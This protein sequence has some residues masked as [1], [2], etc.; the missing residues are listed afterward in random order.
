MSYNYLPLDRKWLHFQQVKNLLDFDQLVS[1]T[2]DAHERILQCRGYLD[3]IQTTSDNVTGSNAHG[4]IRVD[5][6]HVEELQSN[7]LKSHA[8]GVGEEVPT[9]LVK[10][11]LML[12]IKALSFGYSGVQ[13]ETVKRLM[14]LYNNGAI[15]IVYTQGSL[16]AG[17]HVPL[18][19]LSLPL[20]GL[21]QVNY[22]G[23][24]RASADVLKELKLE[25]V[26]LQSNEGLAL[27]TG[28]QFMSAYG[29]YSL[30]KTEQLLKMADAIAALSFD[31]FGC[32]LQ[33][34]HEKLHLLRSHKGQ[35]DTASAI[36][37]YL[38]GSELITKHK[39]HQQD[40]YSFTCI[41]QVHGAAK[42]T[43]SYVLDVFLKEINS[44]TGDPVIFYEDDLILSGGNFHGQ[45]LALALDFLSIAMSNLAS[46]SERRIHQLVSGQ[47]GLPMFPA[48]N[49][50][51]NGVQILQQTAAAIASENKQLC[52]PASVDNNAINSHEDY[53]SMG[54][55]AATKCLRVIDNVEKVLA[56]ELLIASQAI[57]L[58]R[59]L[60]TSAVLESMLYNFKQ[61]VAFNK[62]SV[63]HDDIIKAI[64]FITKYN[65]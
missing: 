42:D 8:C 55:N 16:G 49:N 62:D 56:I 24:K 12:K 6:N 34:M 28:T 27:I 51:L 17:D 59:P 7:L 20:I 54:A 22:K 48:N 64:A 11:M 30:K 35:A 45:P 37:N 39:E 33:A 40:P 19:H 53:V 1:I 32:P 26:V 15:P 63:L 43:F 14:E 36:R 61:Q 44:V 9:D 57:E 60:K 47:S 58:R 50:G 18:S 5:S 4:N 3:N 31:A 2:F 29:M 41:P 46:I 21:G 52:T 38:E 10:L 25:K 13:I 65:V 23:K